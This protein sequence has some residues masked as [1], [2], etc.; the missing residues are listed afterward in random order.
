M[1]IHIE[2]WLWMFPAALTAGTIL[3]AMFHR[4]TDSWD[5]G[6]GL[7]TMAGVVASI[8]AWIMWGLTWLL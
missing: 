8:V 4:P 7:L 5:I 6:G 2:L 3:Y 1:T